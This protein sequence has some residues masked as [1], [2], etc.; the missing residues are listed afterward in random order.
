MVIKYKREKNRERQK[1]RYI[2]IKRD[3]QRYKE[4]ERE[5]GKESERE[6]E[7]EK[8]SQ[9]NDILVEHYSYYR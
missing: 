9:L 8:K 7:R 4:I 6:S 2:D 5:K 3:R 1:Y